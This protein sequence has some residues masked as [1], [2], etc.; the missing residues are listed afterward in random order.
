MWANANVTSRQGECGDGSGTRHCTF[1]GSPPISNIV[2]QSWTL[3]PRPFA[4]TSACID[5]VSFDVGTVNLGCVRVRYDTAAHRCC[6]V[7]AMVLDMYEPRRS[8]GADTAFRAGAQSVRARKPTHI[9]PFDGDCWPDPPPAPPPLPSAHQEHHAHLLDAARREREAPKRK[10][11]AAVLWELQ[12]QLLPLALD[13][14]PWLQDDAVDRVLVEQQQYDN[15]VMRCV[16]YAIVSYYATRR[17][18]RLLVSDPA[19]A[20]APAAPAVSTK[21]HLQIFP[22]TIKLSKA[23]INALGRTCQVQALAEPLAA[24]LL[25]M[26]RPAAQASGG[27]QHNDEGDTD[28]AVGSNLHD[29]LVS[30]ASH[31]HKKASAARVLGKL[32]DAHTHPFGHWLESQRQAKHN[33]CDALLQALAWILQWRDAHVE[34]TAPSPSLP[35][36]PPPPTRAAPQ[37]RRPRE[38]AAATTA[39]AGSGDPVASKH[40]KRARKA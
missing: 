7:H 19:P 2:M 18:A 12:F 8:L 1:L 36:P 23:Y 29:A 16:S 30:H 24:S 39:P 35:P 5:V 26:V 28:E 34:Q 15:T 33:V 4:K 9:E 22:S 3:T 32:F 37:R 25:H 6:L 17:S 10:Q 11:R 38:A 13:H 40:A 21:C 14:V 20:A 27:A 31:A